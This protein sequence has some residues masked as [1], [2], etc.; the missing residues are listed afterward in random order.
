MIHGYAGQTFGSVTTTL[1]TDLPLVCGMKKE[2][3]RP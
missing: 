2:E 1:G 3:D